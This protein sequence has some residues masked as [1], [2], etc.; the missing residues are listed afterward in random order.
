MGEIPGS[1]DT[2]DGV[3]CDCQG[4]CCKR[5]N[6]KTREV[7]TCSY[8]TEENL[9]SIFDDRP[10]ACRIEQ[11]NSPGMTALHCRLCKVSLQTGTPVPEL[12]DR[13]QHN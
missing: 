9:C 3:G 10:I 12:L 8:L 4:A 11:Y 1:V 6:L 7:E 13:L 5:I 2:L